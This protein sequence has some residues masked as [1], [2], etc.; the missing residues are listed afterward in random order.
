MTRITA[1]SLIR[2]VS[3]GVS[4]V[5]ILEGV[6]WRVSVADGITKRIAVLESRKDG[7]HRV[8]WRDEQVGWTVVA[9]KRGWRKVE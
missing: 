8:G 5:N 6:K 4:V 1:L 3:E 9:R 2:D 7:R